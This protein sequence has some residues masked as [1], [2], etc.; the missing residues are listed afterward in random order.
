MTATT[1]QISKQVKNELDN[2][3][4]YPRQTYNEV[5]QKLVNV[6]EAIS[7][8]KELSDEVLAEV[9]AARKEIKEGKGLTTEQL[10]KK[11]GLSK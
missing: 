1:V 5:I 7:E 9:K 2:V 6:F 11:L 4:D 3:K 8:D 10:M